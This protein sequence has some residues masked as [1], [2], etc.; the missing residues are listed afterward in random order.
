MSSP[1]LALLALESVK[2]STVAGCDWNDFSAPCATPLNPSFSSHGPPNLVPEFDVGG[3]AP[4]GSASSAIVCVP[5]LG[6]LG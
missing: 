5:L 2:L 3:F 6:V 1:F 4:I